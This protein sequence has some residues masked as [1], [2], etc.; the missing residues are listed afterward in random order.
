MSKN[1]VCV[2]SPNCS[3][4]SAERLAYIIKG[5]F[6][7]QSE[8][9]EYDFRGFSHIVNYGWGTPILYKK[10]INRPEAVAICV[11]KISTL[12][13]LSPHCSTIQWTKDKDKARAWFI[14]DGI[15]VARQSVTLN[16]GRGL[17]Y[18]ETPLAFEE[19]Q[20]KM[21]TRFFPH[22]AEVRIDVYK[23]TI[24]AVYKKEYGD[25]YTTFVPME[26]TAEQ[27][28]VRQMLERIKEQIGIDFYGI[29]VLVNEQGVCKLLEI[30][31][32][33]ILHPETEKQLIPLLK[34]DLK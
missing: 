21:W 25:K 30:N 9:Q 13:R 5:V 22:V 3:K 26:I 18:C 14:T 8:K 34:K 33:P 27:P 20:A 1:N 7:N 16:Q 32:A 24:L 6:Y 17:F 2:I 10:I 23:G 31:S 11:N 28:E 4:E 15:V 29:D 19:M 12:K